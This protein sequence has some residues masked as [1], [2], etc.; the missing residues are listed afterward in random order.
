MHLRLQAIR[1]PAIRL[2]TITQ[3]ILLTAL[4]HSAQTAPC[5]S[6]ADL[7]NLWAEGSNGNLPLSAQFYLDEDILA[8]EG[9][10][11]AQVQVNLKEE[12]L[13]ILSS[14]HP[15]LCIA[16]VLNLDGELKVAFEERLQVDLSGAK[17]WRFGLQAELPEGTGQLLL[18]VQEPASQ[19]WGA[20]AAEDAGEPL[21]SPGP[22]AVRSASTR[23][24]WHETLHETRTADTP[25][26]ST[27]QRSTD[28][29]VVV[30]LIPPRKDSLEGATRFDA[31]VATDAVERVVFRL[32]GAEVAE[33]RRSPL[34][35]RPF[36]ARIPLA[37]PAKVQI[38][39][40]VAY[41]REGR[42]MGR[43]TLT[44]NRLDQPFRVRITGLTGDPQSGEVELRARVSV[45][46][47]ARL[48]RVEVFRN[49]TLLA[50]FQ[51]T[52]LITR[53]KTPE[54]GPTDFLR[55][56]AFL[57]DGSSIDDVILLDNPEAVEQVE[58]NLVELHTVVT[59]ANGKAL[60]NLTAE[61]FQIIY[62]GKAQ[63]PQ[64]FAYADDVPLLLGVV[65]DT[66]GS[67]E[68]MMHDTKRAAAKFLG[69]TVLPQDRAFLVDFDQRPRL[70]HDT[71]DDVAALLLQLARLRADGAT[72][73]YDAIVFSMLQFEQQPGRK[74]LVVLTDG[75]DHESRYG[76]KYCAEAAQDTG[77]PIYIIGLDGLDS[78]RRTYSKK[79]LRRVTEGTG[80]R[81]YFVDSIPALDTAYAQIQAELRSQ[82]SL[83]FYTD[84][85]LTPKERRE[86]SV[87]VRGEGLT[88]RTVVGAS[89]PQS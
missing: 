61:D 57:A 3:L 27:A 83:S 40:A 71:T 77:V 19:R 80:G 41:D 7:A 17:A 36:T 63:P 28:K 20:A 38:L 64:S 30:R 76:P 21:P 49:E 53:V 48:D 13:G 34:L 87:R 85:D 89:R 45:P 23:G 54:T 9:R 86:V 50:T 15:E 88:A 26:S 70:L 82:Y 11:V 4:S 10:L 31:M 5:D 78:Y 29:E 75:D 44:L 55:V 8:D 43:D 66:S 81:L 39:E 35:E 12:T 18:I 52:N 58:V 51:E 42:E 16:L 24:A 25:G 6:P 65:I 2:Q 79:D 68:L 22:G 14:G 56:A 84:R 46:A 72:A 74:A 62:Q 69:T 60:D 73:M 59:D 32:D 37:E 47:D 67:M 1:L 33:R